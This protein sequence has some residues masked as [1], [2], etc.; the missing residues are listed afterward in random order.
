MTPMV[1]IAKLRIILC[2][3]MDIETL[4]ALGKYGEAAAEARRLG[5][6]GRAQQLYERI[7]DFRA[8]ADVA[9]ERGDRPELLRLL[10]DAK[11][12]AEAGRV[13]EAM[14][15]AAPPEQERGADVYERRRMFAEAAAL[16]ERLGQ[17]ERA[18][19]LYK[20]GQLP[21]DVARL[22][23]AAGRVRDAGITLER[24]LADGPDVSEAARAQFALGRILAG[25][26][27]HDESVRNLQKAIAAA[28]SF[29]AVLGAAS[30]PPPLDPPALARARRLLV[31]ELAALGYREA[32][33][34]LF[35][36]M[37]TA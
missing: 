34:A 9:R 15:S 23:E 14:H 25:F 12:F 33:R 18:R 10:L 13:G 28:E 8:A 4:I 2:D 32:A 7:W 35:E 17:L 24:F 3:R 37:R 26:G 29:S 11:D 19:E 30:I 36:P 27:R 1:R 21:L 5:D 16:R 6:L 20:K 31:V 22:D